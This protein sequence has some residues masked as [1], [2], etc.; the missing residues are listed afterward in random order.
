[1]THQTRED[2][3]TA[4]IASLRPV[5]AGHGITL[6]ARIR[7]TCGLPSTFTRSGTLAEC[8]AD[9]DSADGTHEVM[10]SP[11]LADPAQVLAQ[12]VGALA[13]AA[14]GAMS[15]TSNAFIEAAA[16]LGLCPAG[17][18]WR[19]VQGAEDFPQAYAG[20]LASLGAYPH[21]PL[22]VGTKKTQSTR[23]LKAVCPTCGYTVRLSAKWADKGLPTCPTDGDTFA[24]ESQLTAAEEI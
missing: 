20:V 21:A 17:D 10:I 18:N 8:W 15:H 22:N 3:L 6:P 16:N 12:L 24:L 5:F 13:H 19:M 11:T 4:A 23:M 2:W 9:T 14:P 1:M 7:A